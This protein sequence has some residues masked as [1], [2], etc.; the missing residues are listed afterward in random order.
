MVNYTISIFHEVSPHNWTLQL[1]QALAAYVHHGHHTSQQTELACCCSRW[2]NVGAPYPWFNCN[3]SLLH[4]AM[5]VCSINYISTNTHMSIYITI[6]FLVLDLYWNYYALS[7]TYP[8][9]PPLHPWPQPLLPPLR[10]WI[11]YILLDHCCL[12]TL[13]HEDRLIWLRHDS[14]TGS[15]KIYKKFRIK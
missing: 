12:C 3:V 8:N 1:S 5:H 13:S 7:L 10:P 4:F 9:I 6:D 14:C 15:R 11:V 2:V